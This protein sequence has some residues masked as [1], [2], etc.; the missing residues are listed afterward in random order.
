MKSNLLA[1]IMDM[2]INIGYHERGVESANII[3]NSF[4]NNYPY[5]DSLNKHYGKVPMIPKFLMFQEHQH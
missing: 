3:L 1:D 4:E 2:N 5:N